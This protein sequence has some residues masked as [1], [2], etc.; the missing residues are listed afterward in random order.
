MKSSYTTDYPHCVLAILTSRSQCPYRGVQICEILFLSF[1]LYCSTI[2][3][4][5]H[6]CISYLNKVIIILQGCARYILNI[7]IYLIH[8][9]M[10]I[11]LYYFF[12]R[13]V[14][15]L[16]GASEAHEPQHAFHHLRHLAALRLYRPAHRPLLSCVSL[17]FESFF[18]ESFF[19]DQLTDL[20]C[21]V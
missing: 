7:D 12:H 10:Y 14:Q 15:D 1:Q 9:K 2:V 11:K 16:R 17:S 4:C 8:I 19:I 5:S 21:L 20:S 3:K 18:Y 13:G 6:F